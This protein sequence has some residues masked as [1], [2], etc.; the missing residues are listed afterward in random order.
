MN[1]KQSQSQPGEIREVFFSQ[2]CYEETVACIEWC[3]LL[4]P[5]TRLIHY[6]LCLSP[7]KDLVHVWL[8]RF[9]LRFLLVSSCVSC[10]V[11]WPAHHPSPLHFCHFW[12]AR[13]GGGY[14]LSVRNRSRPLLLHWGL[15]LEVGSPGMNIF[16]GC[17]VFREC[18]WNNDTWPIYIYRANMDLIWCND[19]TFWMSFDFLKFQNWWFALA[20]KHCL[21]LKSFLGLMSSWKNAVYVLR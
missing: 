11:P 20:F 16:S 9:Q 1:L 18:F 10:V 5:E 3:F 15:K 14:S 2:I 7:Q 21:V 19:F 4:L 13:Y 12:K 6:Y 8:F 17:Y